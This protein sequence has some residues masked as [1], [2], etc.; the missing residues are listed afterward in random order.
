[1]SAT[2]FESWLALADIPV[3]QDGQWVDLETG[4]PYNPAADYT[5]GCKARFSLGEKA[6]AGRDLAKSFGGKALKGTA[7]QKEWAEK[8]R[9][10]KI[11]QMDNDQAVM[12]CDPKGLLTNSKFWI[13][14]RV[15]SGKAIGEFVQMQKALL[16]QANTLR[17]MKKT[18]EYRAVAE[19]YNAL[20]AKWGF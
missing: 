3:K 20:T 2:N 7:K 11:A 10:E 18:D 5:G 1:M 14:N 13:E 15:A 6:Q 8:L 16:K 4:I 19:Q 9:A 12:A 17:E